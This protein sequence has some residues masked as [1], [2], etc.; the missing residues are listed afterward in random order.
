MNLAPVV[1]FSYKRLVT[2]QQ[3]VDALST[4]Y[5][6][7]KTDLIIY[8]DG[9]KN[10]EE[11]LIINEVREYLKTIKGFKSVIIHES[12]LNIGLASSIIHGVSATMKEFHK[13]IVLE[14][15]L[16]TSN[17]FLV[18]MNAALDFYQYNTQIL[19][20]AGF[21][22]IIKGLNIN[23]IYFTQRAS[24][25]G[26]ACWEDR[27]EKVDWSCDYYEQFIGNKKNILKFNEMGSDLSL[28]L[29]RQ[30][31][32]KINS[33]AIRFCFHQFQHNLL[34]VHPAISKVKNIGFSEENATNTVHKYTRF[35]SIFDISSNQH[36]HFESNV[37]LFPKIIKQFINDNS[38]RVRLLNKL[39]NFIK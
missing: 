1:L 37:Q 33:W 14:D 23:Q 27:W 39:M 29:K 15:D 18:F 32:G 16:V 3:T 21:S 20:I 24:S 8:S 26:W 5:L 7:D 25:W 2:L 19:S 17:N 28:M 36:F 38:I 10:F 13:A 31:T 30:M 22:P 12:K 34:S 11:Q 4:N 6:A 35:K 9:P